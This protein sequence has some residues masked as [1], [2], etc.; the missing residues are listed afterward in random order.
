MTDKINDE[1]KKITK[2]LAD[3][4]G[5]SIDEEC[6]GLKE[7]VIAF[8]SYLRSSLYP[9]IFGSRKNYK[10]VEE[11]L[12]KAYYSLNKLLPITDDLDVDEIYFTLINELPNIR[13]NLD[14]DI[15]A[16]YEGDPAAKSDTEIML[17]YP[18]FEAISIYRLAHVIYEKKGFV[19]AR[20][21]TEYAHQISG[22]DIHPGATIGHHF[23]IDHGTGVV[24][25]ETA[26]IGNYVKLYQGVTLGAK[27]FVK[28]DNGNLVKGIKR[29][30]KL[31]DN[32][33][34]YANATILGGDTIIGH[35]SVIG[36][37]VWITNSVKP[38]SKIVINI[39][40]N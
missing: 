16:A 18:G 34:V 35:D 8:I 14:Q 39:K 13:K 40:E 22:I 3:P 21:M 12:K 7:E 24:I 32:V 38:Y 2:Q 28:D 33:V 4:C 6:F 11:C 17:S 5:C 15:E 30:P 1:I 19:L 9:I 31:E 20:M 37:N 25:G 10:T 23:F 26:E 27:S 36:G 29:H